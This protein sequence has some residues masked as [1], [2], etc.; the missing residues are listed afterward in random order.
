MSSRDNQQLTDLQADIVIIG[1]GGA[2]LTAAVTAAEAGLKNIILLEANNAPGG[3]SVFPGGLLGTE[4]P[5]QRR[6]GFEVTCDSVFKMAMEYAHW[7]LNGKLVRALIN[8]SGETIVWLDN[9]GVKFDQLLPHYANPL[10]NTFHA[11]SGPVKTGAIIVKTLKQ[12]CHDLGISVLTKTRARKLLTDRQGRITGVQAVSENGDVKISAGAVIIATG[13]F[14]GNRELLNQYDLTLNYDEIL[15]AGIPQKGDGMLMAR[16]IGAGIDN[17]VTLELYGPEFPESMTLTTAAVRPQAIWVNRSGERFVDEN[18][19]SS[20][21]AANAVYKLPNKICYSLLDAR[22][23][24]RIA[25]D[26]LTPQERLRVSQPFKDRLALNLK[27]WSE[28]GKIK[29]TDSL[30]EMAAWIGCDPLILKSE[31]EDY[32]RGCDRGY[33]QVFNKDRRYLMPLRNPPYCA[34]PGKVGIVVTHGGIKVNQ[35]LEVLNAEGK[36]LPGVY[37]AGVDI[38]DTEANSYNIF[39]SGHSFGF[40][41]ISGRL[42]GENAARFVKA[43]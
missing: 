41:V 16:E 29:V 23:I 38:G 19:A 40:S 26:E 28:K 43:L 39:L 6:L 5:L 10:P 15:H 35:R 2:G 18:L 21:I 7:K 11:V 42:A 37:A 25:N 12:C 30:D 1:A 31:I 14:A 36:A 33:D 22:I 27:L 3:N 17:Q 8:R 4:T 34:I 32:N 13:G 20:M 9:K 24:D